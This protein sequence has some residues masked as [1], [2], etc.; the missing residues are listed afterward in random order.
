MHSSFPLDTLLVAYLRDDE[1]LGSVEAEGMA[2]L[3][4]P[5]GPRAGPL[6]PGT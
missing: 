6:E 1:H 3:G 5:H 4:G 2:A